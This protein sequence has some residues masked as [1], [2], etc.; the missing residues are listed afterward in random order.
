M[1]G[2][3]IFSIYTCE[4]LQL[5]CGCGFIILCECA[6]FQMKSYSYFRNKMLYGF[7]PNSFSEYIPKYLKN[8]GFTKKD[9]NIPHIQIYDVYTEIKKYTY[10]L[11][12][13][14]LVYRD[15]YIY[16]SKRNYRKIFSYIFF[17]IIGIYYEYLIF[18]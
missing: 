4:I 17:F 9:L 1:C 16:N 12:V 7:G 5:N 6:R 13:P 11:F 10:F 8:K 3:Q 15:Q 18:I 14:T 2:F